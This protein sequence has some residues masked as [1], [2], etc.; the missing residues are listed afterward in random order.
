MANCFGREMSDHG[1]MRSGV[2]GAE[3]MRPRFNH[4]Y[5]INKR[6]VCSA[7]KVFV[8]L[9]YNAPVSALDP[10][11]GRTLLEYRG[12]EYADEI[13]YRDGLLYVS[14]NDRP[15]KPLPGNGFSSKPTADN[16][17]A[18]TVWAIEPATG[19]LLWKSGPY[20][21]VSSEPDR[22]SSMKQVPLVTSETGV[23]LVADKHTVGRP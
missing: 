13:V 1:A 20:T 7:D 4:P 11:T 10:A 19:R 22:L 21:G 8:T 14:V 3:G 2:G 9:G 18:K 17:S 12:T 5:H 16:V 23:F 15:Q 6:L